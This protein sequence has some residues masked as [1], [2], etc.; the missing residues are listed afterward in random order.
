MNIVLVHMSPLISPHQVV[1]IF[2]F[3]CFHHVRSADLERHEEPEAGRVV[4]R[5][6]EK[7]KNTIEKSE[8][9]NEKVSERIREPEKKVHDFNPTE[10]GEAS[11]KT[12]GATYQSYHPFQCHLKIIFG[13]HT[14]RMRCLHHHLLISLNLIIRSCVKVDV[15]CL[16]WGVLQRGS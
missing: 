12:H 9:M 3:D 1:L 4:N 15:H 2:L 13:E 6:I 10:N 8:E 7:P 5:K 14:M 11:E 16:Q